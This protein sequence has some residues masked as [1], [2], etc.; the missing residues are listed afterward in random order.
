MKR[1]RSHG[2]ATPVAPA[3]A[4]HRRPQQQLLQQT[5]EER[6]ANSRVVV[7]SPYGDSRAQ[8]GWGTPFR[9]TL[10]AHLAR[11]PELHVG[12]S[13]LAGVPGKD[14]R[15]KTLFGQYVKKFNCLEHCYTFYNVGDEA[16][17]RSWGELAAS[18]SAASPSWA[19]PPHAGVQATTAAVTKQERS[20]INSGGDDAGEG[21]NGKKKRNSP[22]KEVA[23]KV[24]AGNQKAP[25]FIFTIKANQYLTHTRMLTIDG[26]T[27]EHIMHFFFERCPLL[28]RHLG[29]VLLQLPPRFRK[30]P[31]HM[32]RV[33]A[34]AARIPKD[35][36]VAVEF[37]HRSW[38]DE[39]VY[40]LLRHV[41][42]ALVVAHHHD[43]P[44]ASVHVDTGVDFM[45]V[46]LHGP[47]GSNVGD[48]GP[49][50]LSQWAE[51]V[52]AYLHDGVAAAAAG[53][54]AQPTAIPT[55]KREVY[56]FLNNS[57]S[58][59]DGTTSSTVDATFLAQRVGDLLAEKSRSCVMAGSH[60]GGGSGAENAVVVRD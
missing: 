19:P 15:M 13:S 38:Y 11:C 8:Y 21:L 34:V 28:G 44:T 14:R 1:P 58:H 56:F 12:M 57:D 52:V 50:I 46:R 16:M 32:E 29:P 42:W 3:A 31:A 22:R 45:Y 6:G 59:V 25:L 26:K 18:Q 2:Q 41:G 55:R 17:W 20:G 23:V 5:I 49:V 60:S 51:R 27:E 24:N 40:T 30:S 48:Y 4:S 7:N 9:P 36:R 39:E 35:I 54:S 47:L 37:R 43:D 33:E 53:T 10:S